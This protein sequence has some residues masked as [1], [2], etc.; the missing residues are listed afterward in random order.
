MT[1]A[2]QPPIK[3]KGTYKRETDKA[4]LFSVETVLDGSTDGK[5]IRPFKNEWFPKSQV[6]DLEKDAFEASNDI[7]TATHWICLTKGLI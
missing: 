1:R 3:L 4:I 2:E 7:L 6:K 5:A